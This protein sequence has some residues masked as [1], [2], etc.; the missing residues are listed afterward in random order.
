MRRWRLVA[1]VAIV[2]LLPGCWSRREPEQLARVDVAALDRLPSG[3]VRWTVEIPLPGTTGA[4]E[5]RQGGGGR[6]PRLYFQAEGATPAEAETELARSLGRELFWGHADYFLV[7]EE[8]AAAGILPLLDF[9][10]RRYQVRR[11]SLLFVTRGA[12]GDLLLR[13]DPAINLTTADFLRNL[14][15]AMRV[16]AVRTVD[17][18]TFLRRLEEP[19]VDPWLPVLAPESTPKGVRPRADG[20]AAFVGDR[21]AAWFPGAA[22]R[23]VLW[24]RGDAGV[25]D[26]TVPCPAPA[27]P[28]R[29]FTA[30]IH[31]SAASLSVAPDGGAASARVRAAG[32]LVEWGCG[33]PLDP[34]AVSAAE[35]VLADRIRAEA[36]AA[37]ER[38]RARQVDPV[39]FGAWLHRRHPA[40]WRQLEPHWRQRLA[41]LAVDVQVDVTLRTTGLT[42]GPP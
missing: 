29:R 10:A 30:R 31:R 12:A 8:A 1:L 4:L 24:L 25:V 34:A 15:R 5:V 39:G 11:N 16:E 14:S 40:A 22:G 13:S 36:E 7:G 23:G 35:G 38:V 9:V 20:L 33:V 17:A 21:L 37:L 18:N 27:A 42:L 28:G 26:A 2:V 6:P 19:G 41:V 32:T 3:R